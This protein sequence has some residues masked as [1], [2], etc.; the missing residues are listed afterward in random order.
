M[1]KRKAVIGSA[2]HRF[3]ACRF[4]HPGLLTSGLHSPTLSPTDIPRGLPVPQI[5]G[6]EREVG[7]TLHHGRDL[8][9]GEFVAGG[10]KA[11]AKAGGEIEA[12]TMR[13]LLRVL[14]QVPLVV[15]GGRHARAGRRL[16]MEGTTA[17]SK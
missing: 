12:T 10:A 14:E 15:L 16:G 9:V 8:L 6:P 17:C 11:R 1:G 3:V 5:P 13:H 2:D 4:P 7:H